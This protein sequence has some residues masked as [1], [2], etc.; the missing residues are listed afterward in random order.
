MDLGF[1]RQV[2]AGGRGGSGNIVNK[3]QVAPPPAPMDPSLE[4]ETAPNRVGGFQ[5]GGRRRCR[6]TEGLTPLICVAHY[7]WSGR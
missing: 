6:R 1:R 2:A 3:D 5:N 4:I 7:S